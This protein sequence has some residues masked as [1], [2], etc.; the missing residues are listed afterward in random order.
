MNRQSVYVP[1]EALTGGVPKVQPSIC[2]RCKG[3]ISRESENISPFPGA[4]IHLKD[5]RKDLEMLL[6]KGCSGAMYVYLTGENLTPY[7][8]EEEDCA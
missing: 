5:P 4:T 3:P 1:P 6:C 7:P 8:W 2:G